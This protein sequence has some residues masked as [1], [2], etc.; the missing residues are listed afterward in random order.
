MFMISLPAVG[1]GPDKTECMLLLHIS[2]WLFLLVLGFGI[3]VMPVFKYFSEEV[4]LYVIIVWL[5]Q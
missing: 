5:C 3:A 2:M 4:A 1:E